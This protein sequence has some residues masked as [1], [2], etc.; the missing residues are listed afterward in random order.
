MKD[1]THCPSAN[2]SARRKTISGERNDPYLLHRAG[3]GTLTESD[4]EKTY[5]VGGFCMLADLRAAATQQG[6]EDAWY[7]KDNQIKKEQDSY[8]RGVAWCVQAF[9]RKM[10]TVSLPVASRSPG[11]LLVIIPL[12]RR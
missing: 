5:Q 12:R 1:I 9:G 7:V 10:L 2:L 8:F 3:T 11:H 4:W 6:V